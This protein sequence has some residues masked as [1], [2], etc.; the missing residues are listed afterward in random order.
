[1]QSGMLAQYLV[2]S[3][4][5]TVPSVTKNILTCLNTCNLCTAQKLAPKMRSNDDIWKEQKKGGKMERQLP[6]NMFTYVK[7]VN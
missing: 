5:T 2:L 6:V 1:M 3:T 4:G 7:S